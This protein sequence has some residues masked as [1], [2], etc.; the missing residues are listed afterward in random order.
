LAHLTLNLAGKELLF[1]A[2]HIQ[3]DEFA[4]DYHPVPSEWKYTDAIQWLLQMP[5]NPA[6]QINP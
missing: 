3:L 2:L 4:T 5:I 1:K 6:A